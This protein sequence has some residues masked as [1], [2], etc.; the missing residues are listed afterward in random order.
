[1]NSRSE[2]LQPDRSS[3]AG[4]AASES[5]ESAGSYIWLHILS[6]ALVT[7][8][9]FTINADVLF[10]RWDGTQHLTETALQ[11]HWGGPV[12]SFH[13][14]PLRAMGEPNFV[15][16][17]R[18]NPGMALGYWIGGAANA[19]PIAAMASAAIYFMLTIATL[20]VVGVGMGHAIAGAWA[21]CFLLLP[22]NVPPPTFVRAWGNM[23]LLP[24][25]AAGLLAIALWW[26][27]GS[28]GRTHRADML[29]AVIIFAVLAWCA[30]ALPAT[31][32]MIGPTVVWFGL[33]R[34]VAV[35]SA[36]RRRCLRYALA[37][38]IALSPFVF[39]VFEV[40]AYSKSSFFLAEMDSLRTGV[41]QMSFFIYIHGEASVLG[42]WIVMLAPAGALVWVLATGGRARRFAIAY[43]ALTGLLAGMAWTIGWMDRG[44]GGPPLA[45]IDLAIVPLHVA[46]LLAP[47]ALA[48]TALRRWPTADARL[49]HPNLARAVLIVPWLLLPWAFLRVDGPAFRAHEPWPWPQKRTELAAF[50]ED[51]IGLHANPEFRG[52]MASLVGI[53]DA[54]RPFGDQHAFETRLMHETGNDHRAHGLWFLGVPSFNSSS[55]LTSPFMH[56]IASRLLSP[57]GAEA[58]RAHLTLSAFEPRLMAAYGV[59]Y[60]LTQSAPEGA[61]VIARHFSGPIE[62]AVIELDSPNL[63]NHFALA[64]ER[65][66]DI[67][68]ALTR[69]A[70]PGFD[71]ARTAIVHEAL[72][73]TLAPTFEA[74]LS[75][76]PGGARF[77]AKSDG[78]ALALLPLEITHCFEMTFISSGGLVPRAL[79]ANVAQTAVL[80]ER[81]VAAEFRLRFGPFTNPGCRLADLAEARRLRLDQVA[82]W[83]PAGAR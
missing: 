65:V 83:W 68:T 10:L 18:L 81:D 23:P 20:R 43:L 70:E 33:A 45:Y 40:L 26:R 57:A 53:K 44:W 28:Q 79:R 34:L 36:E 60:V 13:L 73:Q 66:A 78:I 17:Y 71:P 16:D 38:G 76:H 21:V 55:H 14:D 4:N 30:W 19:R 54:K 63:G 80:F 47:A 41:R 35:P 62:I 25:F 75:F 7:L 58:V 82:G 2:G 56:A 61:G 6:F 49:S 46:F 74:R 32:A 29:D 39:H 9:V 48:I 22:Y 59:R 72:P 12:G 64:T 37:L 77:E 3:T 50:L 51:R 31:A 52:R 8:A 11:F 5:P 27:L 67:R 42:E 1:M 69:L 24:G 15:N